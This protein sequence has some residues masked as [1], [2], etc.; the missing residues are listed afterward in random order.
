M[1]KQKLNECIALL[2]QECNKRNIKVIFK[3]KGKYKHCKDV[4]AYFCPAK[5]HIVLYTKSLNS[6]SKFAYVF[7]HEVGHVIDYSSNKRHFKQITDINSF[8]MRMSEAFGYRIPKDIRN[9]ILEAEIIACDNGKQLLKNFL[10][11]KVI[12]DFKSQLLN[13]YKNFFKKNKKFMS[14]SDS[15]FSI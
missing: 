13:G 3:H 2:K 12:N 7:A 1:T 15:D 8:I 11:V 10:N 4:I 5:K 9:N 14:F 6:N